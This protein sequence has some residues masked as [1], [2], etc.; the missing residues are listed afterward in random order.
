MERHEETRAVKAAAKK[1]AAIQAWSDAEGVVSAAFMAWIDEHG[2]FADPGADKAWVA[3]A[4]IADKKWAAVERAE[5]AVV[6]ARTGA[7]PSGG[8]R[9]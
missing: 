1:H 3:A 6:K 8:G 4:K 5:A 9:P 7:R 2:L